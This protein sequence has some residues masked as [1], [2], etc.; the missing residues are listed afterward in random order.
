MLL[1]DGNDG[2][3]DDYDDCIGSECS[4][5]YEQYAWR[6]STRAQLRAVQSDLQYR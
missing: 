4:K 1:V 6:V 2:W 5:L 3:N